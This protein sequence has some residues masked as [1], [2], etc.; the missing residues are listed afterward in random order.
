MEWFSHHLQL[1]I[2]AV[3]I[4]APIL[5][6]SFHL[7]RPFLFLPIVFICIVGGVIF[8][9]TAGT[10]YSIIGITL[11]CI[12]FY[13]LIHQLPQTLKTFIRYKPKINVYHTQ[14]TTVQVSLLRLVPFIHF[15]ALSMFLIE[16]SNGFREYTKAS[17]FSSIP[18][19]IIYTSIG[20]W[21]SDLTF[22]Q[23]FSGFMLLFPIIY[24]CR[25]KFQTIKWN[26]FFQLN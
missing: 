23:V 8:G 17:L 19:A 6:I 11:S 26:E 3:G 18:L 22:L 14:L 1:S 9:T 7:L 10:F 2:D 5:F 25:R 12:T 4:F 13:G 20:Q 16:T 15:H 24:V 21:L